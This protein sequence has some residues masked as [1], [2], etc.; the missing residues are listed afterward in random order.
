MQRRRYYGD[1]DSSKGA[2]GVEVTVV[3]VRAAT[4]V[5]MWK[6]SEP[7][8]QVLAHISGHAKLLEDSQRTVRM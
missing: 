1:V 2:E 7:T 8:T 5:T 3:A 6:S 4:A